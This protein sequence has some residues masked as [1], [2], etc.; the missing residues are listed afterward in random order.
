MS[1]LSEIKTLD[2]KWQEKLK[3]DSI[4]L[5]GLAPLSTKDCDAVTA[6]ISD[7]FAHRE[8]EYRLDRFVELVGNYPAIL[9][10]WLA[11]KAGEAY[12]YG[13]FW[14]QYSDAI[15]LEIQ[16]N[17]RELLALA[18][19]VACRRVLPEYTPPGAGR[20]IHVKEFL[21]QAALPICHC[22]R[23]AGH[24]R[25]CERRSGL[26]D[27]AD[28]TAGEYLRDMMIESMR[29]EAITVLKRALQSEVG[30]HICSTALN[31]VLS[32]HFGDVNPALGDEL[33]KAFQNQKSSSLRR[34]AR[35]PF[36]RLSSDMCGL[37]IVGPPQDRNLFEASGMSWIVNG[38]KYRHPSAQQ[39]VYPVQDDDRVVVELSGL[40]NSQTLMRTFVTAAESESET[41]LVFD[42][43]SRRLCNPQTDG[44]KQLY[45]PTGQYCILH[46]TSC[47]IDNCSE[48]YDWHDGARTLSFVSISP[49]QSSNLIDS[50][51][52]ICVTISAAATP[53]LEVQSDSLI[54]D[55]GDRIRYA[56]SELPTAWIPKEYE[57]GCQAW[58][59][60]TK[61]NGREYVF[62]LVPQEDAVEGAW[63]CC[64]AASNENLMEKLQNGISEISISLQRFGRVR[65]KKDIL[66]WKGLDSFSQGGTF[67]FSAFPENLLKSSCSHFK[68]ARTRIERTGSHARQGTLAFEI[69]NRVQAFHWSREGT[70]LESFERR[71]G[72]EIRP[73]PCE[74]PTQ[75]SASASSRRW[76]RIWPERKVSVDVQ[77][78]GSTYAQLTPDSRQGYV[79]ISLSSL[80]MGYAKGGSITLLGGPY[81]TLAV[82][83]FS[84]PL[85]PHQTESSHDGS[86]LTFH[87]PDE[88]TSFEPVVYELTTNNPPLEYEQLGDSS[89]D[90]LAF[91]NPNGPT[92]LVEN[93]AA[94]DFQELDLPSPAHCV[95]LSTR[96]DESEPGLWFVELNARRN[97]E[98]DW[99]LLRT[100]KGKRLPALV[101]VRPEKYP[102]DFRPCLLWSAYD[103]HGSHVMGLSPELFEENDEALP[104]LL[105]DV[106]N[107]VEQ[108]F[109][110]SVRQGFFWLENLCHDLSQA[111]SR[112]LH[113]LP[114]ENIRKLL[115]LASRKAPTSSYRSLFVNVPGLLALPSGQYN[116][117]SRNEPLAH[118]LEWCARLSNYEMMVEVLQDEDSASS[119]G[120]VLGLCQ[121]FRNFNAVALAARSGDPHD[122]FCHFEYT[123][124]WDNTI[125]FLDDVEHCLGWD[126]SNPLSLAHVQ[127]GLACLRHR[128]EDRNSDNDQVMG[129]ITGVLGLSE[130]LRKYLQS[131]L[132]SYKA[133]MPAEVWSAPW[134]RVQF[135]NDHFINSCVQFASLFA[136]AARAAG[137]GW[138]SMHTIMDWLRQQNIA[139]RSEEKTVAA[140]IGMAP[141]LF[142]Y[143]LMYWELMIRTYPHA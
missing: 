44:T 94:S 106:F 21:F 99:Q 93:F 143:Y 16:T 50:S 142:G 10:L 27:P 91:T 43:D 87:F 85:I 26:P 64:K 89:E 128:R 90:G 96:A 79:D 4:P 127:W 7:L 72:A 36:L 71:P 113:S 83:E 107:M 82:A 22:D 69:S 116:D 48:S 135:E 33:S 57:D 30:H 55:D 119:L 125:G 40:K 1:S 75:F 60:V 95:Q 124:Y 76:I 67:E 122:D 65:C 97:K 58:T 37:E 110:K 45:L 25:K 20:R 66:Y 86:S 54:T 78:N 129:Q 109:G 68:F 63:I 52:N 98:S 131:S 35:P 62:E 18:F 49:S 112:I 42:P 8:P 114:D 61:A 46:D 136:L 88:V 111:V 41:F 105:I 103:A 108:G 130:G 137:T 17:R 74:I 123:R 138:F 132:G 53:Y 15:G 34:A 70:Y 11:R 80:A 28:P 5:L 117:I 100:S 29:P 9:A 31:V 38:D 126:W 51:S 12:E 13:A 56:I 6:F 101:A 92:I 23:F 115:F 32:G 139:N 73:E 104:E 2:A 140:L 47:C 134:L 39:F 121:N 24:M 118:S 133:L 14:T 120:D 102:E 59:L 77:V 19:Q 141:E 81:D 3:T 84:P